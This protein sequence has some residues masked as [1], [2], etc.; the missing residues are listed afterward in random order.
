MGL[1]D[2]LTTHNRLLLSSHVS[3]S[4]CLHSAQAVPL[5]FHSHLTITYLHIEKA[6]ALAGHTAGGPWWHLPSILLDLAV[7]RCLWTTCAVCCRANVWVAWW[8]AGHFSVFL[9]R[10]CCPDLIWCDF[11]ESWHKTALVTKTGTKLGWTNDCQLL[12]PW[13][14]KEQHHHQAHG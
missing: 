10:F 14:I 4:I 9:F 2:R 1:G 7:S 12:C 6:L 13:L 11:Y 8:S 3:S 5:L